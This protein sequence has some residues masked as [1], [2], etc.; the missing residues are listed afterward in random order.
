[1]VVLEQD[2]LLSLESKKSYRLKLSLHNRTTYCWKSESSIF[3]TASYCAVISSPWVN[4]SMV[5]RDP[6]THFHLCDDSITVNVAKTVYVQFTIGWWLY[7]SAIRVGI[8]P[9]DRLQSFKIDWNGLSLVAGD[10]PPSAL[11]S[12]VI[13]AWPTTNDHRRR[14]LRLYDGH[15]TVVRRWLRRRG[16]WDSAAQARLYSRPMPMPSSV[17]KSTKPIGHDL[18]SW[19]LCDYDRAHT[20]D[21]SSWKHWFRRRRRRRRRQRRLCYSVNVFIHILLYER[22]PSSSLP[23]SPW[24]NT[25]PWVGGAEKAFLRRD[26]W[27]PWVSL[28]PCGHFVPRV[29]WC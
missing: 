14:W 17:T 13:T 21:A 24:G 23:T 19:R 11:S 2:N 10:H 28:S 20:T 15:T 26:V 3:N 22:I 9:I 27:Y 25:S 29:T 4:G 8:D 12:P 16:G 5:T 6:L 18:S 7:C 1:M